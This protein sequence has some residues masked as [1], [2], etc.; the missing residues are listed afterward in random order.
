MGLGTELGEEG[1][2]RE[3]LL[4]RGRDPALAGV[5]AVERPVAAWRRRRRRRRRSRRRR[6]PSRRRAG[7]AA[8]SARAPSARR[9]P[10]RAVATGVEPPSSGPAKAGAAAASAAIRAT[11]SGGI[12]AIPGRLARHGPGVRAAGT[13]GAIGII[14]VPMGKVVDFEAPS[15]P[16]GARRGRARKR[17]SK[18][19]LVLG[20]GGFTGGV[21]EIG[22]LRAIDLLATNSTVNEFDIYVGTSAGAFVSSLVANGVTPEEMM[23]VLNRDLPSPIRDIDLG[24]LL[25]P[26]YRGFLKGSLTFPF[27]LVSVL[28]E[29]LSQ[30]GEVSAVDLVTRAL[31]RRCRRGSTPA[32]GSSATSTRCSPIPTAPTTSACSTRELYLTATDLDTTER[33]ILGEGEWAEVPIS[34]AVA[35]S[36]RPA[37]DLRAGRDRRPRVHRRRHPLDHQ[38]R[39]RGRARGEVHHR[40]QPA[41][42]LRQR[43]PEEHPDDHRLAR[44]AGL[45]HGDRR[46]H[47][48][49]LPAALP[50]SPAPRGRDLGRALSRA[51]TSS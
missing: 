20:G 45:R 11:T 38:R 51:S 21:Y 44:A 24:T 2:G 49:D 35:A 26:N 41:G 23:R 1:G 19:A 4:V 28:R 37:R 43:L 7:R 18:T 34:K 48:P 27:K 13:R 10:S 5:V 16:K 17:P 47:Q 8:P 50:R 40:H 12:R 3:Q 39:R 22:A 33:V 32:R 6:R 36:G 25:T 30:I 14:P 29:T 42:P 9:P 31:A 46:D 15:E